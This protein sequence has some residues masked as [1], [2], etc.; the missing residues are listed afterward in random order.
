MRPTICL[1]MILKNEAH[2]IASTL[3]NLMSRFPITHYAISDT[4]SVDGTQDIVSAF[5]SER[6]VP[7]TISEDPWRNFA[8]NRTL[9]LATART[10]PAPYILIFD[11]DDEVVGWPDCTSLTADA[12]TLRM[13]KDFTYDRVLLVS[14]QKEWE[15]V[16]VVHEYITCST[17]PYVSERLPGRF[18][19]ESGRTGSRSNDPDKYLND[20]KI[21]EADLLVTPDAGLQDRYRFYI[22]QS[23]KDYGDTAQAIKWYKKVDEGGNWTQEK[24]Y[25]CLQLGDLHIG[26]GD[27]MAAI[28]YWLKSIRHDPERIEGAARA[29]STLRRMDSHEMV[30]ALYW[31]Y[32]DYVH[33]PEGKLFVTA[34]DYDDRL[35]E[36]EA[37]ISLY[38]CGEKAE[39]GRA[40]QKVLLQSKSTHIASTLS[41][42]RFYCDTLRMTATHDLTK[43]ACV[44]V[45][46]WGLV[47]LHSSTGSLIP[48]GDGYLL[49]QRFVNYSIDGNNYQHSSDCSSFYTV[50]HCVHLD[51]DLRETARHEWVQPRDTASQNVGL[52][53]VRLWLTENGDVGFTAAQMDEEGHYSM[54]MGSYDTENDALVGKPLARR[55]Y[56][57]KN[58]VCTSAIAGRFA[59]G[60]IYEWYPLTICTLDEKGALENVQEVAAVPNLFQHLRGSTNGAMYSGRPL[61]QWFVCHAVSFTPER[62]YYHVLVL[63]S[64]E[65][66]LFSAPFRFEGERVEYCLGL[67]VEESRLLFSYST[68]DK[69]TK[70]GVVPLDTARQMLVGQTL[71]F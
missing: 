18:Y 56:H 52:E 59:E 40:A 20:A 16:G 15:Y 63:M 19:V 5:F 29:M 3:D 27:T 36:Y 32:K 54:V 68:Y 1:C 55:Q 2:V 64:K 46:D 34:E 6:K 30:T 10:S 17:G 4:G 45:E 42:L 51:A 31:R 58:W 49:N 67:V 41:N 60:L 23:Y 28:G 14:A 44:A 35:I 22:A 66:L 43:T 71:Y 21:M 69:T 70:I 65:G 47:D 53:D 38:Y 12:Y 50:N 48:R 24:C 37:S 39:A 25:A 62:Q 13:G 9:A 26:T 57:E 7:G 8:H 33:P 61:E 11:G